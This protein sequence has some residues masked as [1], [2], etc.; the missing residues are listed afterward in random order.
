MVCNFS[1]ANASDEMAFNRYPFTAQINANDDPVLP[2]VY[3]TKV[4]PGLISPRRSASST[5]D[6]AIRSL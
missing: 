4:P 2:P 5:I 1:F 3:S 6:K